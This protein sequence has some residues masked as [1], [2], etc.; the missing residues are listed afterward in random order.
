MQS[1][2]DDLV[3]EGGIFDLWMREARLFKYGS[4]S[5]TNFSD[6]RAIGEPLGGGGRSSGLMSF[7]SVGDRAAGVVRSGG[8]TRRAAKMVCLD[9]DHP[10]VE[11]FVL[12]KV[13][14]EHKVASLVAGSA[15]VAKSLS[16]IAAAAEAAKGGEDA[17][18]NAALQAALA[19]GR[20]LAIPESF[21][22][23]AVALAGDA[24]PAHF[25]LFDTEWE[26]EAYLTIAGQNANNSVRF[27]DEFFAILE[28]NGQ[29]PLKWRTDGRV[30]GEIPA[31][32]LW[33]DIAYAAWSCA[34]PGLQFDTTTNDWH[35]CPAGGRIRASNPCVTGDTLVATSGGFV[36]I[37]RMTKFAS[38]VV[39][40]D[41]ELHRIDPAFSTGTKPVYRL[42]TK[43]GLEV[44]LTAD[45][46]V[47][48]TNRG[49]VPA[50]NLTCDDVLCLGR[51]AFGVAT[52]DERL[53]LFLGLL[54][55]DG[56]L[57]HPQET[58]VMTLAPEEA[59]VAEHV[60]ANLQEFKLEFAKDGRGTRESTV[61][62]PQRT[63]R[64]STSSRCVVD[65]LKRFAI[66][67][68]G[69]LGKEFTDEI[70]LLDEVSL[71]PILQGLFTA[72]GTVAHYGEKS[73][74]VS[75]DSVSLKLLQQVQLLLLTFGIKSKI[76]RDRRPAGQTTVLMKSASGLLKEYPVVQSHSLRISRSS[77]VI[78][79][80]R[81]GF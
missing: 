79:E 59:E 70:F 13:R 52:L 55:G 37:E 57:V 44:Q 67:D 40:A 47:L 56:C 65:V 53:G 18:K 26:G 45:H 17:E 49:D 48:T 41:G 33:D 11:D 71:K 3:N 30:A 78:F 8:T 15:A 27:T 25:P 38:E 2:R 29:W 61:N 74:Y 72:D 7:L 66:L 22:R 4:G 6:L 64:F 39:G 43:A 5:G 73:Q 68:R 50:C 76:Y 1:I 21:L 51:P 14:E 9:A 69:S 75:L 23:K 36:A 20:A 81:I 19:S 16:T 24:R 58:A 10:E 42:R 12:W 46:L 60:R 35:T 62:Q 32:R 28:K 34:D 63:L 54:V 77:R 31:R 80:E